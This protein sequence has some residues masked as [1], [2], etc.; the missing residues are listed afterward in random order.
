MANYDK[1]VTIPGKI[2]WN[3]KNLASQL[4]VLAH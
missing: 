1:I 2:S 4:E 3:F